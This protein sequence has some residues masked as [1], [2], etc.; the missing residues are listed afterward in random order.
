MPT[1]LE[2]LSYGK[3]PDV[4]TNVQMEEMAKAGKITCP[5]DGSEPSVV[6]FIQCA[7]SR[8]P[9]SPALLQR[10]LLPGLAETG[11]VREGAERGEQG[12]RLLQGHPDSRTA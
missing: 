1:K 12:L 3:F 7:G 4:I 9:E 6:A 10:G 2:H 11:R 8:D 5:S